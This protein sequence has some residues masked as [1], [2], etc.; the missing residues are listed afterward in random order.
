MLGFYI[1]LGVV[2]GV[3][4]GVAAFFIIRSLA[5]RSRDRFTAKFVVS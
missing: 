1:A 5:R 4:A 3:I 2:L